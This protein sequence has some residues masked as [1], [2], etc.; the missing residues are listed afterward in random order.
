MGKLGSPRSVAREY[1]NF[2]RLS[3]WKVMRHPPHDPKTQYFQTKPFP[4]A[5]SH[6]TKNLSAVSAISAVNPTTAPKLA[7][8]HRPSIIDRMA[9]DEADQP[10]PTAATG[11]VTRHFILGTAGHIDHGKTLLIQA[12]TGTNTDRL[13]EE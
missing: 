2:S 7:C 8:P 11:E 13:P 12:L 4:T 5:A 10:E 9:P 6:P 1:D 3:G